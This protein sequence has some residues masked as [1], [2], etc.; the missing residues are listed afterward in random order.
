[1][2]AA[3]AMQYEI[4]DDIAIELTRDFYQALVEG[5]PLDVAVWRARHAIDQEFPDSLEWGVPVLYMRPRDGRIFDV[6]ETL[7]QPDHIDSKPVLTGL[8]AL[9]ELL[10]NPEVREAVNKFR[11]DFQTVYDHIDV[12]KDYK[13]LHDLL[14]VL[15]QASYFPI[16][17]AAPAYPQG[18]RI[19]EFLQGYA[20]A[21]QTTMGKL[22]EVANHGNVAPNR[23]QWI[24]YIERAHTRLSDAIEQP[25]EGS[26]VDVIGF[27]ERVL[28]YLS[29]IN[30]YLNQAAQDLAL[31]RLVIAV[32]TIDSQLRVL[33]AREFEKVTRFST[34]VKT[35]AELAQQFAVRV[36]EHNQWQAIDLELQITER[37]VD[38]KD[39]RKLTL[40]WPDLQEMVAPMCNQ[41]SPWAETLARYAHEL[42]TVLSMP[43]SKPEEI[44]RCFR[45]Y[46]RHA[47]NQ[48]RQVDD[49]LRKVCGELSKVRDPLNDILVVLE[50]LVT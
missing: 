29:V 21:M 26:L 9:K 8:E 34:G 13:E 37:D 15:E 47:L 27:L 7:I 42:D 25:K 44:Q 33:E 4:S 22:Q 16:L 28:A 30:D 24:K 10:Q 49:T 11:H 14:Q 23:L 40:F 19:L 46:R 36:N 2:P 50:E 17:Q 5:E 32:Q 1:L 48:F 43:E 3:L 12:V 45:R 6:G 39:M 41:A 20:D 35:L 31:Q 38:K 18:D